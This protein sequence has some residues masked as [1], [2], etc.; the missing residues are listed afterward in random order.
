MREFKDIKV[1]VAGT[2]YVGLSIAILLSQHHHVT[3]VDVIPEKVE[4]LNK[5]ISPIQDEYIEKYLAEKQLNLTA[6]LDGKAAYAD[7]DFVVI[8][9]PTNY[10]PVK[11]YFD[12]S[13]VEEVID[14]VLKV[15]PNAVMVIK[16]TIPVGYTRSL[17]LKYAQRGVKKFNL[18]FSPEFLRESKALYD[19][20]YPSRIIVG[21]PKLI[22]HPEM[23]EG[24]KAIE[25]IADIE[26][27]EEAAH[28]FASL[29]LEGAIGHNGDT[30][31]LDSSLFTLHS[32][33]NKN[34]PVIFM[35]MK[36]AEA[37]K[38]FAN[39]YLA[40][41]VSYFNELDTY[42]EVKGLDSQAIIEGVG[43][44]PRIGTHYNNPSFGYGGYCLPKDTKQLLANYADVPQ[45]M[46]TAIVE[47]NKTRKDYIADAVLRK[48]GWYGYSENNEYSNADTAACPP[49]IGV[50]R[51]T[52]KSNSDN[53]RQSAIQGIMKRVK[54]KGAEVIIYEPT[55]QDGTTFFGS[56]VINNL[57]EFK[58][59]SKAIIANRFDNCLNDVADKV[60]T[61]DI[62]RRD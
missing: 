17:Y 36:E 34:I 18:L 12:T 5:R 54:A 16:S 42:A 55:L 15:N 31:Q 8:A 24:N 30:K 43:L 19:N 21:Y 9:A 58:R 1:A 20:L 2:G 33:L 11:N 41:R 47:S 40:L 32:S 50:Y 25:S 61:R 62:F 52:M 46:M 44:D 39:T 51:L 29:L 27:L 56:R 13:H 35:G 6:T 23:N 14:L 3:A 28:T 7:A 4:K 22:D 38:L 37:V 10:D 45:N 59:L 60:Y 57:D 26:M 53:F 49:V 48:A